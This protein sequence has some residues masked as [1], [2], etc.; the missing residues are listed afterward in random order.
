MDTNS[1]NQA[2]LS[3]P[4]R[5]DGSRPKRHKLVPKGHRRPRNATRQDILV[6]DKSRTYGD[7]DANPFR[8]PSNNRV[9]PAH[10]TSPGL[11]QPSK[12]PVSL[13]LNRSKLCAITSYFNPMR[14]KYRKSNYS[15]FRKHLNVP[16]ITVELSFNGHFDLVP[17]D[18]DVLVQ[19]VGGDVLWQK[20]RLLNIAL[21]YLPGWCS[22]VAW[23][24]NDIAFLDPLWAIKAE[25]R[26]AHYSI[27][28]LFTTVHDLR[29][30]TYLDSFPYVN[31]YQCTRQSFVFMLNKGRI[32]LDVM[33]K[34]GCS[35]ILGYSPGHAWAARRPIL[36]RHGFYDALVLGSGDKAM[37][38]AA[39]AQFHSL[40][41]ALCMTQKQKQHFF[42]WA[43]PYF[44]SVQGNVGYLPGTLYHYWHGDLASRRY[45]DRY[46]WF[47]TFDFDPT[48]DIATDEL[49]C[50]CWASD[51]RQMKRHVTEYFKSRES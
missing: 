29:Q 26:L 22:T 6:S 15:A 51:K 1:Q 33:R 45:A 13:S 25:A 10:N 34:C 46:K 43:Q 35:M 5:F 49:G 11:T 12:K 32:T 37:L 3:R 14:N 27:L 47:S 9:S 17:E 8:T 48:V 50:W 23:L 39:Y 40:A 21:R 20:E 44:A 19:L 42:Q 18:A 36:D 16:L 28:Q 31:D 30:G 38:A 7:L 24:D 41:Q 4:R 2:S